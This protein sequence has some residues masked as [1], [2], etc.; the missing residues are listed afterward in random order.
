MA[1]P[2]DVEV[3]LGE[4]NMSRKST[5]SQKARKAA[6]KKQARKQLSKVR[7]EID[8][9]V[10]ANPVMPSGSSSSRSRSY[11]GSSGS[12]SRSRSRS[13]SESGSYYSGSSRSRSRSKSD[14]EKNVRSAKVP[15]KSVAT[16]ASRSASRRKRSDK[17]PAG[18]HSRK[19]DDQKN[20]PQSPRKDIGATLQRGDTQTK[21][22]VHKILSVNDRSSIIA[23]AVASLPVGK[24]AKPDKGLLPGGGAAARPGSAA[25]VG[26]PLPSVRESGKELKPF[27]HLSAATGSS[28]LS[29][30]SSAAAAKQ[31]GKS[32][33]LSIGEE[34]DNVDSAYGPMGALQ[35]LDE[36]QG[37]DGGGDAMP[38]SHVR[39]SAVRD[40]PAA[41][42]TRNSDRENTTTQAK[43]TL[44]KSERQPTFM[45]TPDIPVRTP[46][47]GSTVKT[48]VSTESVDLQSMAAAVKQK[49]KDAHMDDS[50]P[51]AD[52]AGPAL[53]AVALAAKKK[54]TYDMNASIG[55]DQPVTTHDGHVNLEALRGV[56]RSGASGSHQGQPTQDAVPQWLI[57]GLKLLDTAGDGLS[58][59]ELEAALVE[60]MRLRRWRQDTMDNLVKGEKPMIEYSIFPESVQAVFRKWDQDGDGL[61][62]SLCPSNA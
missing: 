56:G 10:A 17:A 24:S 35:A 43:R 33:G 28:G 36:T 5:K 19:A 6:R 31:V 9:L 13:R 11:S 44:R 42:G 51:R 20:P 54:A 15:G 23:G 1:D 8:D 40:Q 2:A 50:G 55:P 62:R 21:D 60:M 48:T 32:A 26:V 29:V 59:E 38:A 58:R 18:S 7:N 47:L 25:T 30:Q 49:Y 57:N 12:G 34:D 45:A 61:T 22:L 39:F 14:E 41:G 37:S 46:T 53:A 27:T 4:S 3:D 16:A 52:L